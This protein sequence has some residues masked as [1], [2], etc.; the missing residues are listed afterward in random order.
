MDQVLESTGSIEIPAGKLVLTVNQNN[1]EWL[2]GQVQ[3]LKAG[4]QVTIDVTAA[5]TRWE[6]VVTAIG[7]FYKIVTEGLLP[8][9]PAPPSASAMTAAWSSIP[10]TA[11]SPATAWGPP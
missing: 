4:D 3:S 10:L 8:P 9:T 6:D 5:D 2:L 11:G 1:N 7:G